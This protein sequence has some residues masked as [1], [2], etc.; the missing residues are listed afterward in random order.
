MLRTIIGFALIAIGLAALPAVHGDSYTEQA[1]ET[2]SH[3]LK[4][5][6]VLDVDNVSGFIDVVGD[7]GNTIRVEGEKVIRAFGVDQLARA[8]R[9]VTLDINEK[10]GVAQLYVNGPFRGHNQQDASDYHGFRDHSDRDYQVTYNFTIHV[11]RQTE[12]SLRSVNGQVKAHDTTGKFDLHSVNGAIT[13]ERLAGFGIARTVNGPVNITLRE[14]P[15][16]ACEF[17]TVNGKV[18]VAFQPNLSADL[19]Y[20]TLNGAVYTD[21][22]VTPG[23]SVA[24]RESKNGMFVYKHNRSGSGRVGAGGPKLS[25]ET[26]NGEIQIRKQ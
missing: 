1:R 19:E 17:R 3:T 22:D 15:K 12:L 6:R 9:E 2:F 26:L 11:P 7:G 13:G 21:F 5:A 20:K 10:D 25:F 14:N 23:L 16:Q 18:V 24:T 4:A 8:K